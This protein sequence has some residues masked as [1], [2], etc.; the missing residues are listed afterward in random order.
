MDTKLLIVDPQNDFCDVESAALPVPGAGADLRRL[1]DL[2]ARSGDGVTEVTLTLDS[3]P[4]VGIERVTF[5]QQRGGEPVA[6]FTEITL[7]SVQAGDYLP[8]SAAL[9]PEVMK[10]LRRLEAQGRYRL[11]VWPVH[12][13]LG[14][15]GHNI[16]APLARAIAE[17]EVR[18]QRQATKVL[19]GMNS[20]TEHYSAIR[21]EV[22]RADDPA[23]GVNQRL[24]DRV[25]PAGDQ[26]LLV[27]GEASSHCVGATVRDLLESFDEAERSRTVLLA[28]CMS[29]VPGFESQ[30]AAFLQSASEAGAKLI[31]SPA[32]LAA[33][34]DKEPAA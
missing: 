3:H 22:P 12:C 9:L 1:S 11:M 26:R 7:K 32:V 23:T 4:Y 16:Y 15:P 5:W 34:Q 27:A 30:A 10:Y 31:A 2:V 19:K 29:P 33:L 25:R 13:V 20:L 28:D 24:I 14:T 17:W 8:R 6:P 18:T 21:A